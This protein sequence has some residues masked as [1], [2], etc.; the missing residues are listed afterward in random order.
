MIS[1]ADLFSLMEEAHVYLLALAPDETIL[2]LSPLLASKCFHNNPVPGALTLSDVVRPSSAET[3]REAIKGVRQGEHGVRA[4]LQPQIDDYTELPMSVGRVGDGD[5]RIF[6]FYAE[7]IDALNRLY[8]WEKEERVKELSCLYSIAE[9]IEAS[10]TIETFFLRLPE[11]L[12]PGMRFPEET[13]VYA[14]FNDQPYGHKPRN[15]DCITVELKVSGQHRGEI[16][17]GYLNESLSMLSEERKML[18]E[19]GRMLSSALEKK[20]LAQGVALK[21]EEVAEY[22]QRMEKLELDIAVREGDLRTQ[23]Q[24]LSTA[25]SYLSEVNASWEE[26]SRRLE[27]I[28]RAIPDPIMLIDRNLNVVMTNQEGV[29]PGK[30]CFHTFFDRGSRCEDCRLARVLKEKTPVTNTMRFDGRFYQVNALPVF[31]DEQEIEGIL[32]FYRDVT[33]EKSYEKQLQQADKLASLGQLVSGIGHEINNPNQFIRGNVKIVKQALEDMLPIVDAH[34]EKNPDL[35]IA[36]L[37]YDFLREHLMVLVDDMAH[38]SERIKGIVEGLR[39]FARKDEG[40][41]VDM[42]DVNTLIQATTRLVKN[43]VHKRADINLE[44]SEELQPFEGN[45]QK[46]EQVLVNLIVNAAQ[47]MP[48]DVHGQVTVRTRMEDKD[49]IIEIQDNGKGMDKT[50]Q[51]QIFDPFFT[52]K[53]TKGGTGLGLAIAF[54]IIEEHAGSIAV[55]SEINVGTTFTIRISTTRSETETAATS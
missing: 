52:T 22:H 48:D 41:L 45:S 23:Q 24:K 1:H 9:W 20:E 47:A 6:I 14:E 42:V 21:K 32:E 15:Q 12:A 55:S 51:R 7:Q 3:F 50:T 31:N 34:Y 26:A 10:D 46:I 16:T 33:L 19:I 17:V 4:L 29:A 35:K 39:R 44:L 49:V 43:E 2:H 54:R 8:D 40:L 13:I 38:G 30:K 25:E 37:K 28:F 27:T 53:R 11:Y 18:T 36:R 5:D